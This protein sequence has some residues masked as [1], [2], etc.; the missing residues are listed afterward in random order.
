MARGYSNWIT[1]LGIPSALAPSLSV[2]STKVHVDR[3][4]PRPSLHE[5]PCAAMQFAM[6]VLVKSRSQAPKGVRKSLRRES[7]RMGLSGSTAQARMSNASLWRSVPSSMLLALS[8]RSAWG[9]SKPPGSVRLPRGPSST[10]A[11]CAAS[12]EDRM[13]VLVGRPLP[14][15]K[16]FVMSTYGP[17]TEDGPSQSVYIPTASSSTLV[18]P[19]PMR[20]LRT[21]MYTHGMPRPVLCGSWQFAFNPAFG[22]NTIK[23]S[24]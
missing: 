6:Q 8:S 14:Y 15:S 12:A 18:N 17:Q 24:R 10:R 20:A 2:T 4:P 9:S 16:T 22:S 3:L 11:S 19:E 13:A 7:R 1:F 21:N 5:R 23:Y